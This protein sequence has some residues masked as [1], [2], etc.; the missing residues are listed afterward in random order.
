MLPVPF[1]L[2]P[3]VQDPQQSSAQELAAQSQPTAVPEF[4]VLITNIDSMTSLSI[5]CNKYRTEPDRD[6]RRVC[7]PWVCNVKDHAAIPSVLLGAKARVFIEVRITYSSQH[8]QLPAVLLCLS[9]QQ[10]G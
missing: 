2:V 1:S 4:M 5:P 6:A 10:L 9:S 3:L 7:K 8:N